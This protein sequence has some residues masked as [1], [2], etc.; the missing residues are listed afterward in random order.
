[1][2]IFLRTITLKWRKKKKYNKKKTQHAI[3]YLH[4]TPIVHY[5]HTF[6]ESIRFAC[7][8]TQTY[9]HIQCRHNANTCECRI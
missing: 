7:T 3:I 6:I 5:I 1:M 2:L 4:F 8:H 9:I